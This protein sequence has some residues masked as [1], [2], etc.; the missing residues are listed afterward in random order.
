MKQRCH[1]PASTKFY[2][3]GAKGVTVCEEWLN[4]FEQ[5]FAD[6]GHKPSSRHSIERKD[7][8]KGYSKD[9]CI[10]ATPQEQAS[11]IKHNRRIVFQGKEQTLSQWGRELGIPVPTLVNRLDFRHMSIEE[12]FT[13]KPFQRVKP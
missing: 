13:Y 2:M 8:R 7:G 4:S 3:Y 9:N 10:W 11:N 12:A 5:F 6:M 1:N